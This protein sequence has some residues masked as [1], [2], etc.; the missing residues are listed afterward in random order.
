MYR[1]Y[2]MSRAQG[3]AGATNEAITFP[4]FPGSGLQ[5]RDPE[6]RSINIFYLVK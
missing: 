5:A 6:S 3:C 2:G 1:M 4:V